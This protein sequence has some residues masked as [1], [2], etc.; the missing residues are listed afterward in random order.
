MRLLQ[1][2]R[3]PNASPAHEEPAVDAAARQHSSG[4]HQPAR[5]GFY[6]RVESWAGPS[7]GGEDK[8]EVYFYAQP[9]LLAHEGVQ[10]LVS[11]LDCRQG[12]GFAV[13]L[14]ESKLQ[15]W[16]GNGPAKVS[17]V[18]SAF[19]V[20]SWRWLEVWLS[21][22]NSTFT[23]RVIGL[24]HVAEAAPPPE[25]LTATLAGPMYNGSGPLL[26]AAG[27]FSYDASW[28]YYPASFFNGRLDSPS[29]KV[30]G[31]QPQTLA[32]YNFAQAMTTD[33]IIDTSGNSRDG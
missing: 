10:T 12:T 4:R 9:Y 23:A 14:N 24:N 16:V 15:F 22:K 19:P 31:A 21:F 32:S 18:Q 27:L 33:K 29:F 6:G 28:S 7:S 26:F 13:V 2:Y 30:Q 8:L 25:E 5:P 20:K 1:G 11:T 17:R 3:H